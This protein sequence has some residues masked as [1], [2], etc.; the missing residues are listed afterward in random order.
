MNSSNNADADADADADWVKFDNTP[1]PVQ[2]GLLTAFQYWIKSMKTT[3]DQTSAPT[4]TPSVDVSS[5]QTV[6]IQLPNL[7]SSDCET[8]DDDHSYVSAPPIYV[9]VEGSNNS[10][11]T[12]NLT[13]GHKSYILTTKSK[14]VAHLIM[15]MVVNLGY[16]QLSISDVL[17]II[18][19]LM[20]ADNAESY[21]LA[22]LIGSFFLTR[23]DRSYGEFKEDDDSD[24]E[25]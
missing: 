5:K 19:K 24:S 23:E 13:F 9:S 25:E 8:Y 17:A 14:C 12:I 1:V 22:K 18:S 2:W 6:S 15:K 4:S 7:R 21:A 20:S 16:L 3:V 11:Y 10:I